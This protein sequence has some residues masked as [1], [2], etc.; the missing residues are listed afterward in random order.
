MRVVL[1]IWAFPATVIGLVLA[2]L[3]MLSGGGLQVVEGAI[4]AHGGLLPWILRRLPFVR[5]GASALTLGHVV[6]AVDQ[7]TLSRTRCHERV[8]VRQYERWGPFLIPAY[9]AVGLWLRLRGR[10]AYLDN[11]F[12]RDAYGKT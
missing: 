7:A 4:E 8:H 11:P 10:D 9:L 12:E 1:V 3:A 6:V 2:A 5:G